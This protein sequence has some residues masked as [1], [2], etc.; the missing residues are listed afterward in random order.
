MA[1]KP[2][3]NDDEIDLIPLI[4]ALWNHK[5]IILATTLAG[6]VFALIVTVVSPVQWTASTYVTKPS[7]YNLY[8]EIKGKDDSASANAQPVEPVLYNAIQNDIFSTALGLLS[9]QSVALKETTPRTL[10]IASYTAATAED[11]SAQL[12]R[13]LAEANKE[14]LALNLPTLT[15]ENSVRAFNTLDEVKFANNKK[16]KKLMIMGAFLGLILGS[17]LVVVRFLIQ[18]Y[19]KSESV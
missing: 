15:S 5:L 1:S 9:A 18:Q 3:F 2:R 16:S 4:Q 17:V 13:A 7:L 19:K 6:A 12:M 8:E 10:Y 11:A 14:A